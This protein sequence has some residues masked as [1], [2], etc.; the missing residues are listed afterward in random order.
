MLRNDCDHSDHVYAKQVDQVVV[1]VGRQ[2]K[3]VLTVRREDLQSCAKKGCLLNVQMALYRLKLRGPM[4]C[5]SLM[6]DYVRYVERLKRSSEDINL[7]SQHMHRRSVARMYTAVNDGTGITLS[8]PVRKKLYVTSYLR[9]DCDAVTRH[10]RSKF[11]CDARWV[12]PIG[13]ITS[14]FGTPYSETNPPI[15][16]I[17]ARGR[18]LLYC[19]KNTDWSASIQSTSTCAIT[20]IRNDT[21]FIAADSLDV[22]I[23]EG[24]S[25]CDWC[26]TGEGGAPYGAAEDAE[27]YRLINARRDVNRVMMVKAQLRG[28][29]WRITGM[30]GAD[31]DRWFRLDDGEVSADVLADIHEMCNDCMKVL[32][33]IIRDLTD[34][35]R[36]SDILILVNDIC[37]VFAYLENESSIYWL[38]ED[39]D[40]FFRKGCIRL[41]CNYEVEPNGAKDPWSIPLTR[42]SKIRLLKQRY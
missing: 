23:T 15:L 1:L 37:E 38:A 20:H 34:T 32:G 31:S 39:I 30:P 36:E 28:H 5:V 33:Y 26:Y 10:V 12:V 19:Y 3:G 17:D 4:R 29:T 16:M 35:A 40:S 21:L 18:V 7:L 11:L 2:S 25:R 13:M 9:F 42:S 27:M 22:L 24:L 8:W 41:Y 6:P 14:D